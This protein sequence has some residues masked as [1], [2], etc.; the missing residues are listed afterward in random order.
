[1]IIFMF[2]VSLSQAQRYETEIF[3]D[4]DITTDVVYGVNATVLAFSIFGE[5]I[6]QALKMDIYEPAGD[7]Q[8]E[9]PLMLVFHTG[10]FLPNVTNG[11]VAGTKTDSSVVEIC[12]QLA[13]RGF[14][15]ASV[16]YRLGWNPL[17]ETQPERALGLIQAA[18]RGLQDGRTAVRFFKKTVAEDA[19]LYGIDETKIAC[20]GVG[21]GGYLVL[22]VNGLSFYNEIPLSSNPV[23]KF[24][25]D[26]NPPD[27]VPE[28]PMVVPAYHGDIEGKVLTIA[29]DAAFGLPAGDTTNYPNHVNYSSD[30]HL[31]IQV[32]GALGDISWLDDQT[33]PI[34]SVQSIA[35][36]FAP[37]DDAILIVPTTGD[38]IVQVQGLKQIGAHQEGSGM[39]QAW[40]DLNFNDAVTQSAQANAALW[41]NPTDSTEIGH[42]YYEGGFSWKSP[43]N[44]L[45]E[46]E[47]VVINW[48]DPNALSPPI[49][50]DFPN[51]VPWN[52][53]PYPAGG[54]FHTNGLLLNEG[55][56]AEKARANIAEIMAYVIPRALVTL[57][58]VVSADEIILS[59]NLVTVAPNPAIGYVTVT[60]VENEP[61]QEIEIYNINGQLLSVDRNINSTQST[62]NLNNRVPGMY[63]LKIYMENGFI[64]KK[65]MVE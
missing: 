24:L 63:I 44:S 30:F 53:L 32:G 26:V 25:L 27:G 35:D 42:P 37:Y 17:A 22:G 58:L 51:G 18:Y 3:T 43:N 11:Q 5:A 52:L 48:W 45:G 6:P 12:T 61:I 49:L 60:S 28:T 15:A 59:P 38:P 8:A 65:L 20:W 7:T 19:N 47:G 54:T 62:F 39:N 23:G 46:D 50:P 1:L 41:V 9:R 36:Q 31:T 16:D 33:V 21:T 2:S 34:I 29:P 4:V 56:S 40:K 55:M 14:V 13:K 57:D 64:T 10:N